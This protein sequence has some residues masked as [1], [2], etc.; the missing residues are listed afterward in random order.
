MTKVSA[1]D[2]HRSSRTPLMLHSG[3]NRI[4]AHLHSPVNPV[5]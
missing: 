5:Q 4:F 2:A 1:A 3:K